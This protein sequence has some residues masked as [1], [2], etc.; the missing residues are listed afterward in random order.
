[1]QAA[2]HVPTCHLSLVIRRRGGALVR[3][4]IHKASI[5]Q[6]RFTAAMPLAGLPVAPRLHVVPKPVVRQPA[7]RRLV[8]LLR[9][10]VRLRDVMP[11]HNVGRRSG[12][13]RHLLVGKRRPVRVGASDRFRRRN[14]RPDTAPASRW[15]LTWTVPAAPE[16]GPCTSQ[17][18]SAS[19][20]MIRTDLT[21][22][23]T[24]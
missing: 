22:T 17:G 5:N 14:A 6:P 4:N 13:P 12:V 3:D 15:R 18:Q 1:M 21:A 16:T 10:G 8:V 7:V 9:C 24:A 19:P 11:P 23:A 20:G 2:R